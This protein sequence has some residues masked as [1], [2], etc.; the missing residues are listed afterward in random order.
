VSPIEDILDIVYMTKKKGVHI[1]TLEKF[2]MYT[3]VQI[4]PGIFVH[5]QDTFCPGNIWTTLYIQTK[6]KNKINDR[7]TVTN[8]IFDTVNKYTIM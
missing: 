5:K 2:H 3:V 8:V 4:W 6:K 1:N 7:S